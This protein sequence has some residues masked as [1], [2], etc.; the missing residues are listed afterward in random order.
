MEADYSPSPSGGTENNQW[1]MFALGGALSWGLLV[2][3]SWITFFEPDIRLSWKQNKYHRGIFFWLYPTYI[4]SDGVYY[5]IYIF[6]L[7]FFPVII[8]SLLIFTLGF[9]VYVYC[10]FI[11]KYSNVINAM[12]G[13]FSKFH[14]IPIL[15]ASALFIISECT[16]D[17]PGKWVNPSNFQIFLTIVISF[18][19]LVSM[20]FIY[21][22]T[23]LEFPMY[24]KLTIN[25]GT[26]SCL[27]A[28]FSFGFFFNIFYYG[29]KDR[30][31]NEKNDIKDWIK[32]CNYAFS[33][34]FGAVNLG[35]SFFFKDIILAGINCIMYIGMAI[36]FFLI[37]GDTMEKL[38]DD[39]R[40]VGIIDIIMILASGGLAAFL[41]IKFNPFIRNINE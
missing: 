24:V 21:F 5:P 22:Q 19:G 28:L 33:I 37:D 18:M 12:F 1:F 8:V 23:K 7:V 2:I 10:I 34:I 17:E 11:R 27:L 13:L 3:T 14:F 36:N 38:F 26:Y 6:F 15:C 39:E 4:T 29:F 25:R 35:L 41:F 32:G 40:I 9:A 16:D 30:I 31:E 20:A